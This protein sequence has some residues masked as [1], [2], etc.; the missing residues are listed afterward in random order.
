MQEKKVKKLSRFK[1]DTGKSLFGDY[2]AVC[3]EK[4]KESPRK[5]ILTYGYSKFDE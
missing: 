4:P 2:V 3:A 1:R 5:L